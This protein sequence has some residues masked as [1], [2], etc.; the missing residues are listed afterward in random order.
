MPSF[1]I[2]LQHAE[3]LPDTTSLGAS[4]RNTQ[5][6]MT[7]TSVLS[8]TYFPDPTTCGISLPAD[9]TLDMLPESLDSAIL[10]HR[11][12]DFSAAATRYITVLKVGY[13]PKLPLSV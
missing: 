6:E 12:G 9:L 3:A 4:G 13:V 2:R 10:L 8:G 1:D 7:K 5:R 11:S